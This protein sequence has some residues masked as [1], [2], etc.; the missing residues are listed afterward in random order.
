MTKDYFEKGYPFMDSIGGIHEDGWGWDPF[1]NF[2]GECSNVSCEN[3]KV[4]FER[5]YNEKS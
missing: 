4:F 5:S 3:C 2:C 1:G